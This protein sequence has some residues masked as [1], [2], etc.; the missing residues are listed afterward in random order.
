MF[1]VGLLIF[2]AIACMAFWMLIFLASY[3][4]VWIG[5]NISQMVKAKLGSTKDVFDEIKH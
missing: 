1:E 2:L 5:M 4:P 3:I